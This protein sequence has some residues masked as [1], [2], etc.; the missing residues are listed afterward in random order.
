MMFG[1]FLRVCAVCKKEIAHKP[2]QSEKVRAC[3]PHCA[4]VLA[5]TEHPEINF[6]AEDA[7]LKV[8]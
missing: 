5:V 6:Y 1:S 4:R 2:H 7:R 8:S 3:G